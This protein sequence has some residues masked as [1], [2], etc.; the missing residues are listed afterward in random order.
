MFCT[1]FGRGSPSPEHL[2]VLE[3]SLSE[4]LSALKRFIGEALVLMTVRA[5]VQVMPRRFLWSVSTQ[6]G[7]RGES[8]LCVLGIK[9]DK[10]SVLHVALASF[11]VSLVGKKY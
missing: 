2:R 4:V 11:Q 10:A 1:V 7:G 3:A 5:E 8:R 6:G 9:T